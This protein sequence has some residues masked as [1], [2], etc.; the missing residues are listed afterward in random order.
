MNIKP[1][2]TEQDYAVSMARLDE[3]WG[4]KLGSPEGDELEILAILIEKYEDQHFAMKASDPIEAIKFRMDQQG[5][6]PRDLEPY[7]GS[8]GRVSEVLNGKRGLS[9]TMI[10]RL[11]DGLRI[12]YESLFPAAV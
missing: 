10:K 5:L 7:I 12:P 11:H 4:A 8:S 6:T 2:R 3:L 9:L 1:V